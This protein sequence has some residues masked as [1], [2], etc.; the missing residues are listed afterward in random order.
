V[1]RRA[2][3]VYRCLLWVAPARL[4]A[5]HGHE[6]EELFLHALEDARQR[7]AAAVVVWVQAVRD[8]VAARVRSLL[9]RD[10]LI[11]PS[12][13]S[14]RTSMLGSDIRYA[15][16][17][18][19]RQKA[20]ALLVI[21]MLALGIA[22]NV[23]VFS[24]V[25][26]L[27][28]RPFPFPEPDRLVY[29]N[30][31]APQWN[32]EE[33]GV[34]YYDFWRWHEDARVFDSIAVYD[35]DSFN[36]SGDGRP[37]RI[38]GAMVTRDL[39]R[40]LG[41]VPVLGRVFTPEE[42]KPNGPRVVM[43]GQRLWRERFGGN[44]GVIGQTLRLDGEP[45]TIVGVL[46][47][48]ADFPGDVDLWVPLAAD[49]LQRSSYRF[50]GIGR[51]KAGVT[52][53]A[54]ERDLLR[55]QEAVWQAD[56]RSRAVSPFV[57]SLHQQFVRDFNTLAA[58][59]FAG[60]A[61]LLIVA[62]ANVASVMLARTLARRPEIATRLAL[63]ATRLRLVRQ[64]FVENLILAAIGG[65]MGLA[66]GQ[67]AVRLIVAT[68][69]DQ[70]PGWATY[71]ADARLL[72]FA[73]AAVVG[74]V[75]LFGWAPALH[76][77]HGDL[78]SAVQASTKGTTS[79]PT[80]RRTLWCLVAGEFALV[81]VLLICGGLLLRA[82][83]RVR[84][85]DPGFRA[86]HVLTFQLALP[87]T[88]KRQE[89]TWLAFWDR[90]SERLRGL[91]GVRGVGLVNCAPLHNCH[92][93]WFFSAEGQV[94]APG[95]A[96]PV[97]LYRKASAGYFDAIGIRLRSGRVFEDHDG[98]AGQPGVV[99]VNETFAR[100]FWPVGTDPVGRHVR[101]GDRGPW[102]TVVGVVGDIK[103]YGLE[104]PVR[105][106]IYVPLPEAARSSL[107]VVLRTVGE[108]TSMVAT[109]RD[110]IR[111]IDPELPMFQVKTME[112]ALQDSMRVRATYSWVLAA[113]AGLAFVLAL[114]GAYGVASYLVS[115]RTREIGIRVA[116][117]A[118][119]SD[120]TR[121]IVGHGLAVVAAGVAVGVAASFAAARVMS[122]LLFETSPR[123]LTLL[124]IVTFALLATALLAQLL[125][126]RRAARID[127]M[128]CLRTD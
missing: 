32:L 29:I 84:H 63:G 120:I 30:E 31:K 15:F 61:L 74:T 112:E 3:R 2:R 18:L 121:T 85:V 59:L 78:R 38:Q 23:A 105:P 124:A 127:P 111:E 5:R 96:N 7:D 57:R 4:R 43:I 12:A 122:S 79:S 116:L 88:G 73:V 24:F 48:E 75:I 45:R 64:L 22:A 56:D 83:D 95:D 108:P 66:L 68:L 19:A 97:V 86:D 118:R 99:V 14:R 44:S 113:F 53:A 104:R 54:A 77:M 62:C 36:A 70:L 37:D 109:A 89:A 21:G 50:N 28:L 26:G 60:V 46:P 110:A 117:G 101:P 6:M 82:F 25:N 65:V 87:D 72:A 52:V 9:R 123:D 115:Q 27:F 90:L 76:A 13:D 93:G 51:L 33:T 40:V 103:H 8:L 67:W 102:L 39:A 71:Q 47:A 119:M 20:S 114:G 106:G 94:R 107:T 1:T 16:R 17:S 126:A 91:P 55:A 69:S 49:P 98:R 10:R 35:L 128:R 80:G 92:E 41:I 81:A 100:M 125:P 11:V 34:R 58:T 42:D